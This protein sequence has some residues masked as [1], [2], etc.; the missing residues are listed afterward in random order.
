CGGSRPDGRTLFH[1]CGRRRFLRRHSR[2]RPAGVVLSFRR[3]RSS[4]WTIAREGVNRHRGR[5]SAKPG[6]LLG[7]TSSRLGSVAPL[8]PEASRKTARSNIGVPNPP[9]LTAPG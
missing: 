5:V 8:V 3:G 7:K 4:P 9:A 2:A 6:G 1:V